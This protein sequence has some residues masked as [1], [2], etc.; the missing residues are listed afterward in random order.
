MSIA[1]PDQPH[2]F[3][4]H[5]PLPP[6]NECGPEQANVIVRVPASSANLG[7]GFDAI[8][9]ALD[10]W[11]EFAVERSDH[12]EVTCECETPHD[13]PL[14]NTNL[15]CVGVETAFRY[16]SKPLPG[17]RYHLINRI[18]YA[19]GLGSSS[20][21]IV[22]GLL[23]GVVLAGCDTYNTSELLNMAASIEGH[24]DNVAAAICG[25]IRLVIRTEQ[26]WK[27]QPVNLPHDLLCVC[28]VPEMTGKTATARAALTET[29]SRSDAVF[30]I[31]RVAWLINSLWTNNV[32]ELRYGVQDALHQS[33]RG[34][35]VY[36]H[37]GPVLQAATTA[38]ACAAYLSGAGPAVMAWVHVT[39]EGGGGDQ[40]RVDT[41][42]AQAML[43][44]AAAC[45]VKGDVISAMPAR[46][47]AWVVSTKALICP[48]DPTAPLSTQCSVET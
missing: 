47:G 9:L 10:V 42:V 28:F 1:K 14:D 26:C 20:A 19:R 48:Q 34:A 23:A 46:S 37:L 13:M 7:P 33:Q 38:G 35:A 36:P 5:H 11:S 25:G 41:R 22:G 44:A 45:N 18:P 8:G 32:N 16:V 4:S 24:G 43:A 6:R 3:T 21:A 29:V 17:L 40:E 31:G 27:S 12:F 30:N 39:N 2:T 15:V